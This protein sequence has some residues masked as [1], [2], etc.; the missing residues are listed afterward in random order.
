MDGQVGA[1]VVEGVRVGAERQMPRPNRPVAG[2]AAIGLAGPVGV[3]HQQHAAGQAKRDHRVGAAI[4]LQSQHVMV[5]ALGRD[6]I[7]GVDDRLEDARDL[8]GY[9]SSIGRGYSR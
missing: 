8:H 3:E 7:V 4:H 1:P 5:E 2:H 6:Q 9:Y